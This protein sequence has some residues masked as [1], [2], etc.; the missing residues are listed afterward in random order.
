MHA[1]VFQT[2][3]KEWHKKSGRILPWVSES[4]PYKIWVSEV[5]LQQTRVRQGLPYYLRFIQ[6]FP[7]IYALAHA[8]EH[9][10]FKCWEGLG[11]YNRARNL[12]WSAKHIVNQH[13]GE[14]PKKY[15]DLIALKG[16]GPYTA[17]AIASFAF[18]LPYAVLDGNVHRVLSRIFSL[19]A[20]I[21]KPSGR[22]IIQLKADELIDKDQPGAFN[23]G[24]MDLGATVCLPSSPLCHQ[25]PF[26]E[27]CHAFLTESQSEY[28]LK[29]SKSPLRN[30][31]FQIF[32]VHS[33]TEFLVTQRKDQDV[34]K[35]LN[36]LPLI[37]TNGEDWEFPD[38]GF[39]ISGMNIPKNKVWNLV[40][41]DTQRLTH[42]KV[43]LSYH[44]IKLSDFREMMPGGDVTIAPLSEI[45][46]QVFPKFLH[47]FIEKNKNI[48]LSI[49]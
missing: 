41:R 2:L 1:V 14:F 28:P 21:S 42:Q 33:S 46:N 49:N 39:T 40:Q 38:D 16:V 26:A 15:E 11:Y 36:A 10:V 45:K 43:H 6:T 7:D 8:S 18:S 44:L 31:Y 22:K 30:R 48:F 3:L 25:C 13:F 9:E 23:Q 29:I 24:L 17:A 19:K 4:N 34:W 32:F 12:H 27:N 20:D 35:G 5:I 37:E 47:R